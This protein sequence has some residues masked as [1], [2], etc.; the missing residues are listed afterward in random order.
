M[1]SNHIEL[2][3]IGTGLLMA[4]NPRTAGVVVLILGASM[5]LFRAIGGPA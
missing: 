4:I 2:F 5:L 1:T 3:L